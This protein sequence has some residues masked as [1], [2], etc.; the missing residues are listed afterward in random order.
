MLILHYMVF[1]EVDIL[2]IEILSIL[3]SW[4]VHVL[5]YYLLFRRMA[6]FASLIQ[7]NNGF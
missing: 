3:V 2:K 4:T 7:V 5:L 6:S 1:K